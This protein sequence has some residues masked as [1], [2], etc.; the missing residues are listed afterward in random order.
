M[1]SLKSGKIK[2]IEIRHIMPKTALALVQVKE[3]EI[4]IGIGSGQINLIADLSDEKNK[5]KTFET[6]LAEEQ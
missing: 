1:Q 6:I 4:L 5:T 2:I 3:K